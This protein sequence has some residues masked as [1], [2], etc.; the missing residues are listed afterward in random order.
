MM[1]KSVQIMAESVH[2]SRDP[3]SFPQVV[4][5][6]ERGNQDHYKQVAHTTLTTAILELLELAR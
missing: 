3:S 1:A 5:E 2:I 4:N 6:Q